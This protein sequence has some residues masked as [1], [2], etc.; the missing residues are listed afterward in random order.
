MAA[1][2]VAEAVVGAAGLMPTLAAIDAGKTIALANKETLV[3]AGGVVTARAA[4]RGVSIIPVDSE[5][6]AIFQ[7][8]Q[9]QR[10]EDLARRVLDRLEHARRAPREVGEHRE[11]EVRPGLFLTELGLAE[12]GED[13]D[14]ADPVVGHGGNEVLLQAADEHREGAGGLGAAGHGDQRLAAHEPGRQACG[15]C[16]AQWRKDVAAP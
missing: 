3:M 4:Q 12:G 8:L 15:V 13:E 10:R 2:A 11:R 14:G 7:C 16:D 1:P 5:H 6:S 9:G